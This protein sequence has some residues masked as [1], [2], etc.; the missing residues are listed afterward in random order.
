VRANAMKLGRRDFLHFAAAV[1]AS[2]GWHGW[3]SPHDAVG[4]VTRWW[5]RMLERHQLS[6]A[7]RGNVRFWHKADMFLGVSD[8]YFWG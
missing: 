6:K 2:R 5:G 1:A 3:V 8:V 7:V 4:S